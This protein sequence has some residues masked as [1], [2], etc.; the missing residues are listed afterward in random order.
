[1]INHRKHPQPLKSKLWLTYEYEEIERDNAAVM[2]SEEDRYKLRYRLPILSNLNM[3][4]EGLYG[5]RVADIYEWDQSYYA[6]LDVER[7]NATPDSQRYLNH[8]LLSQYHL[9]TREQVEAK[10]DLDWQPGAD[11]NLALNLLYREN[12]YDE[13]ELGLTDEEFSSASFTASWIVSDS[14]VVTAWTSY[15]EYESQQ[16]GLVAAPQ[17][18]V[19]RGPSMAVTLGLSL[20]VF[21]FTAT[22]GFAVVWLILS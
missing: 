15:N 4:L 2:E 6:R 5:D 3:R 16:A 8:P 7:I 18:P 1:M 12:D 10:L 21:L 14:L 13:T 19:R 20:L 17:E 11:W 22:I 9:A